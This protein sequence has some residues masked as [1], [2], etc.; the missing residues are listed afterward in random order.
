[1][2]NATKIRPNDKGIDEVIDPKKVK[3]KATNEPEMDK[4]EGV[5]EHDLSK[6]TGDADD[7]LLGNK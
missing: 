4:T 2:A 5:G 6:P 1:M 7:V 3:V